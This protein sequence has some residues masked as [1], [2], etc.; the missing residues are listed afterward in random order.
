MMRMSQV[1]L[2]DRLPTGQHESPAT[3]T[4]V[5]AEPPVPD[6]AVLKTIAHAVDRLQQR[7]PTAPRTLVRQCVDDAFDRLRNAR[8]TLYLP[9]LIERSAQKHAA[10]ELTTTTRALD[11]AQD[12]AQ[13]RCRPDRSSSSSRM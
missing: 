9:I 10:E 8:V 4:Q 11:P 13:L 2:V 5:E 12:A 1:E 7:Y 3:V 6:A